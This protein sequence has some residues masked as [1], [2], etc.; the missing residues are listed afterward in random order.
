MIQIEKPWTGIVIRITA[1]IKPLTFQHIILA[2][3]YCS[4]LSLPYNLKCLRGT[5][6][7]LR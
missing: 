6:S 5:F 3:I 1:K 2:L 4:H 7:T